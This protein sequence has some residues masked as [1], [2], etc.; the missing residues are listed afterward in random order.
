MKQS[1]DAQRQALTNIIKNID[2]PKLIADYYPNSGA[3]ASKKGR[4]RADWRGGEKLSV[5]LFQGNDGTWMY[6]DFAADATGNAFHWLINTQALAKSDAIKILKG[7]TLTNFSPILPKVTHQSNSMPLNVRTIKRHIDKIYDYYDLSGKLIHQT[8][9]F[10]PKAF[11][12]RR[13]AASAGHHVWGLTTGNYYQRSNGDWSKKGTGNTRHFPACQTILYNLL[14][15]EQGRTIVIVEGEKDADALVALGITATCN[16][17]G[18]GNWSDSELQT[19]KGHEVVIFADNDSPDEQTGIS[20]G[21]SV[22]ETLSSKLRP[23]VKSLKGIVLMPDGHK[24]VSDYIELGGATYEDIRSLINNAPVWQPLEKADIISFTG[25]SKT[26]NSKPKSQSEMVFEV[27]QSLEPNLFRDIEGVAYVELKIR[28]HWEC[29]PVRSIYFKHH[30][31]L[32]YHK[33]TGRILSGES[34]INSLVENLEAIAVFQKDYQKVDIRRCGD[35]QSIS[36]DLGHSDWRS[37]E[38]TAEGWMIAAKAKHKLY[39]TSTMHPL[40]LPKSGG[41]LDELRKLLFVDDKTWALLA[42]YM[43][44]CFYPK[45]PYPLL[46]LIAEQGSGKSNI[47]KM[48]KYLID[49]QSTMLRAECRDIQNLFIAARASLILIFDNLSY[50]SPQMSDAFCILAT[51]GTHSTR[52]FYEQ[53]QEKS[54][55]LSRPVILTGITELATR[56]DLLSRSVLINLPRIPD[57]RRLS[58][59]ELWDTF[60][61]MRPRLLGALCD[62]AVYGLKHLAE[63]ETTA[64][65]RMID[66]ETWVNSCEPALGLKDGEFQA[67]LLENQNLIND[68]ALEATSLPRLI[69]T[70]LEQNHNRIEGTATV[71]LGLLDEIADE[72]DLRAKDYPKTNAILGKRLK[73]IKPNL[74]QVGI[75]IDEMRS[76]KKGERVYKIYKQQPS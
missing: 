46:H 56:S 47:A 21:L 31:R 2:L 10:T 38:I 32:R 65:T 61:D 18:G 75:H 55:T 24:D 70:L 63:Q 60:E 12:Q 15:L 1:N 66:F 74:R 3:I 51:G 14:L 58:E 8:V 67:A 52:M 19:L 11:A 27:Y 22:A 43:V 25:A 28:D 23:I 13:P 42:G 39:R 49:P 48:L 36:I 40:P 44:M 17:G 20:K 54:L 53:D 34:G 41:R 5:S 72:R 37:I 76:G 35:E 50:L 6:K 69:T 73:R 64:V 57:G 68:V 4:C 26:K 45:G 29:Y 7:E 30:I 71:I 33:H 59:S 9:R 62:A 16:C